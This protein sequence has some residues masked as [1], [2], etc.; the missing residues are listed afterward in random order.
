VICLLY[1]KMT[2]PYP[3]ELGESE[4]K[5]ERI[6]EIKKIGFA[7][8][9]V[10]VQR[11]LCDRYISGQGYRSK[12]VISQ[13]VRFAPPVEEI[14]AYG[15]TWKAKTLQADL[16]ALAMGE[17]QGEQPDSPQGYS[18]LPSNVTLPGDEDL[19]F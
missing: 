12:L 14:E 7:R 6:A 19:P 1:E 9:T 3:G 18:P 13:I 4:V 15:F 8:A 5:K 16:V 17:Y 10:G 11:A 2:L